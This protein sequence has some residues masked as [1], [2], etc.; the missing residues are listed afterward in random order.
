MNHTPD[1]DNLIKYGYRHY[2]DECKENLASFVCKDVY[3]MEQR[4]NWEAMIIVMEGIIH[5]AHRYADLA[6]L[7]AAECTDAARRQELF[8]HGGKLQ[9]SAGIC[10]EDILAGSTAGMVHPSCHRAGSG[11]R[12]PLPGTF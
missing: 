3:D 8:D 6:E 9:D 5:F 2:I 12:R 1:Y 10:P 11:G 4:I 7:Q